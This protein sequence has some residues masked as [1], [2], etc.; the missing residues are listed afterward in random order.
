M[1]VGIDIGTTAV[2]AVAVA[3]DGT[4]LAR[5]RVAHPLLTDAAD[6]L[7]HD[8][9]RAWCRGPRRALAAVA[10]GLDVAGV[11]VAAMVPSM[12]P[13]DRRGRPQGPGLLYGDR[14][15]GGGDLLPDLAGL[16]GW[17]AAEAPEAAGYWPA[18]AVA[19]VAIGGQPA[20]DTAVAGG[21]QGVVR[22][23][24]WDE[25]AVAALGAR[26]EQ[27]PA[28]VPMGRPA[29]TAPV[30]GDRVP[31]VVAAGTVDALC[32]QVVAGADQ[33]GDVLVVAGATLVVWVVTDRWVEVPGLWSVPHT[34]SGL[35][36]VG[37]PSNAGALFVDWARRLTGGRPG[38]VP[39]VG[40]PADPGAVPVWLPY[41]RGERVPL[42]DA[43]R[44]AALVDL[45]AGHGPASWHRAV[46]EASGFVVRQLVQ[47]SGVVAR[48]VVVT[49]GL[50][51]S[52]GWRQAVADVVGLPVQ[53]VAVP[54]GGALGAAFVA[55][56]AAGLEPSVDGAGAWARPGE[57]VEPDPRWQQAADA[58]YRRFTA[59]ASVPP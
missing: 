8:A 23:G 28:I 32:E 46:H 47:R 59:L 25:Q 14:R 10:S 3:A 38:R 33:V 26:V 19:S 49:G 5:C 31:A 35:V 39:D 40:V 11:C 41:P 42:H 6:R 16:V 52:P 34:T 56:V 36:L 55:R 44:R 20:I 51:R 53:A 54:E 27:L 50:A 1:T 13:V 24:R 21:S 22:G 37:G 58:R 12:T 9:A 29:G 4:V 2:K 15:A 18:Q 48:R 30:G 45:D 7:E 57:L 43:A 17:A